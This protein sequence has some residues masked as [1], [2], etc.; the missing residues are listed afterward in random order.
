M[1]PFCLRCRPSPYNSP[2]HPSA[3]SRIEYEV[4]GF[5]ECFQEQKWMGAELPILLLL[6]WQPP[7]CRE[8]GRAH[9]KRVRNSAY[10]KKDENIFNALGGK[11]RMLHTFHP[12]SA[13]SSRLNMYIGGP[14]KPV[15]HPPSETP[16]AD[17]CSGSRS[18]CVLHASPLQCGCVEYPT[19]I[20][21]VVRDA[22]EEGSMVDPSPL[23]LLACHRCNAVG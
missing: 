22:W 3:A 9:D 15:A 2:L 12:R 13:D 4:D 1:R 16:A 5:Q 7:R 8:I 6:A 11:L 14:Q 19:Y 23:P 18:G 21:Y 17:L 10:V 20:L